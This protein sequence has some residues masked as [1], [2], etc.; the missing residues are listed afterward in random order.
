LIAEPPVLAALQASSDKPRQK[1]PARLYGSPLS[2]ARRDRIHYRDRRRNRA[3]IAGG[4]CGDPLHVGIDGR[5]QGIM[6]TH[7]N[8]TSFVDWAAN[9]FSVSETDKLV[10]MRHFISTCRSS[11]FSAA[12]ADR[13]ACV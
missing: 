6:L 9:T 10:N 2:P 13:P 1:G 4:A 5:A 8:I 12:S 7:R 3:R 11:T